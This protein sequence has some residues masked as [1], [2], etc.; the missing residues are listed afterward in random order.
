VDALIEIGQ[1]LVRIRKD[2]IRKHI[3]KN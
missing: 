3:E 2:D 1:T